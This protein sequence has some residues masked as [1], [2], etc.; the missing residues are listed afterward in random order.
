MRDK[1]K[2]RVKKIGVFS[3]AVMQTAALGIA[4]PSVTAGAQ[5]ASSI[6]RNMENLDRGVVAMKVDNGTYISWRRLGTEPASTNFE[7][8]RNKEKIA[9]GPITNYSDPDGKLGDSYTVV[10]N[11]NMS[12][13]APV[14]EDNYIE[15]P[16][17]E[18]PESDIMFTDRNG[19]YYGAYAPGDGTYADL[20]GDG[21]YEIIM[22]WNPP[23]AKDAA[24]GGT[25][26]K[27]VY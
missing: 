18:T 16:L 27:S 15:I 14:L 2:K 26:R 5:A 21:Q 4:V 1:I 11:G 7:L 8:Y 6:T 20:D 23:D 10:C 24:S 9:E 22:M 12:D 3:L 19:I 13:P 25:Y 17:A